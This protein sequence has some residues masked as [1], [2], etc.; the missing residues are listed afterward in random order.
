MYR[1]DISK[2][3]SYNDKF[4]N[5]IMCCF[6]FC[7]E[8]NNQKN[9]NRFDIRNVYLKFT[10]INEKAFIEIIKDSRVLRGELI[11]ISETI[12]SI[13]L[14]YL[15]QTEKYYE[16]IIGDEDISNY[17]CS[18]VLKNLFERIYEST[19][20]TKVF[21]KYS[22][23]VGLE[24]FK[25]IYSG[26]LAEYS[27]CPYCNSVHI[28][29]IYSKDHFLP[30]S[31]YPLLAIWLENLVISCQQ[32]NEGLKNAD[33]LLPSLHP[34]QN[35]ITDYFKF[36][37]L[38]TDDSKLKI[39]VELNMSKSTKEQQATDNY[40]KL[41]KIKDRANTDLAKELEFYYKDLLREVENEC[42][43]NRNNKLEQIK[44]VL[45]DKINSK[46]DSLNES[47]VKA[48]VRNTKLKI[49]FLTYLLESIMEHAEFIQFNINLK[50]GK[51]NIGNIIYI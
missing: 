30:K 22:E 49:D 6:K 38:K 36:K 2:I 4:N 11:S 41:F 43:R 42:I 33:T 25:T 29:T 23:V 47:E 28:T 37:Y 27:I 5:F 32:C 45:E 9:S 18:E 46:L 10:S 50:L 51:Y 44:I 39:D 24:S 3:S 14:D 8:Y 40:L 20:K 19:V 35:N 7:T 21:L 1:I 48:V 31:K 13:K 26:I 12:D 34:Y 15:F 16:I 17:S